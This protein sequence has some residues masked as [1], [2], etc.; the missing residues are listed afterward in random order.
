[1]L[2]PGAGNCM[3]QHMHPRS[4]VNCRLLADA[5]V[6][7]DPAEDG[8]LPF[9]AHIM[10]HSHEADFE[11][12]E[13]SVLREK[14]ES[15]VDSVC[16]SGDEAAHPPADDDAVPTAP[17]DTNPRDK[18]FNSSRVRRQRPAQEAEWIDT[19][20]AVAGD[21]YSPML[22]SVVCS[23]SPQDEAPVDSNGAPSTSEPPLFVELAFTE[24]QPLQAFADE[25]RIVLFS[26][27]RRLSKKQPDVYIHAVD[28][29]SVYAFIEC[30][31]RVASLTPPWRRPGTATRWHQ[32]PEHARHVVMVGGRGPS[33]ALGRGGLRYPHVTEGLLMGF[34][35]FVRDLI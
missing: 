24:D 31:D 5:A 28:G 21:G 23:A 12:W 7:M 27:A 26:A 33:P 25:L 22:S 6:M 29:I 15:E 14:S 1:M 4:R 17:R 35:I 3:S 32:V 2:V 8:Q 10:E 30:Y 11:E 19:A 13:C 34:Y 16:L 9:K 20:P 18:A